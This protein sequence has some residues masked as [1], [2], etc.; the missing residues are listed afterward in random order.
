LQ[1]F[2][3]RQ[4][5]DHARTEHLTEALLLSLASRLLSQHARRFIYNLVQRFT[6]GID[7]ARGDN[8]ALAAVAAQ[9]QAEKTN[10]R[11]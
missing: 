10:A 6:H 2:I 8:A 3:L 4:S 7:F 1:Y 11:S 9:S 5:R